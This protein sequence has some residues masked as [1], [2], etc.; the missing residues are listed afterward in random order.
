MTKIGD[1][2]YFMEVL[3]RLHDA[4]NRLAKLM[5]AQLASP[6]TLPNLQRAGLP[7]EVT[8]NPNP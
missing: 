6:R 7:T 8:P 3:T 5:G 2:L 1:R 4:T